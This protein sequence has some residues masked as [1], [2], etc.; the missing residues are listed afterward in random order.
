MNRIELTIDSEHEGLR[1]DRFLADAHPEISRSEIQ[2]EI[3]SGS[4]SVSGDVTHQPSRRLRSSDEIVWEHA[5]RIP[6]TPSQMPL[7]IL[8]EDDQLVVVSKSSGVVV[9][10]GAGTTTPTLVEGLL[11]GRTLPPSDDPTRPGIV[12]RLDKETSGALVAAKTPLALT[13]LQHQFAARSVIKLY[14]AVVEGTI[15]E[16]EGTVDAPIGRDPAYPRRMSIQADGRPARTDFR[17]LDRMG[18]STLVLARLHTGRTHQ[19]RVHFRYIG[20]PV[21]GDVIY[22]HSGTRAEGPSRMLL[23][24][25]RLAI[26]HPTTG[27]LM[28]FEAPVPEHFPDYPFEALRHSLNADFP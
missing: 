5:E 9:H 6:V 23:H 14:V 16:D 7:D 12:H 13:H 27:E 18:D 1:L 19:L 17:V 15:A 3:R 21:R 8:Y 26:E 24:A 22:G 4:V 20:H 25:W 10:P 2:R 11:F 28:T